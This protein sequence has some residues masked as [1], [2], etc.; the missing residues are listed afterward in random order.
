MN[1]EQSFS[2]LDDIFSD[3]IKK[4]DEATEVLKV[5]AEELVN[6]VR[7]LPKPRSK[8]SKPGYTHLLESVT[9]K[10]EGDKILVGWGKYYGPMVEK[11][12]VKMGAHPHLKPTW[13]KNKDRYYKKMID[14]FHK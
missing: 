3:Y 7:K 11:G 4:V 6:D 10:E 2:E 13:Q 12:T 14:M 8:V 5:G 9:L 1:N